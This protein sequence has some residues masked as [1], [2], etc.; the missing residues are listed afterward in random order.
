MKKY[1]LLA[2][3]AGMLSFSVQASDSIDIQEAT[4]EELFAE[5]EETIGIM[6]F[7]LDGYLSGLTGDTRLSL[8]GIEQFAENVGA[9]CAKSPEAKL[10]G[11][12]KI[13]GIE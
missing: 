8:S 13:V 11:V 9:A 5:D 2:V 4:C 10:L 12:A 6:L 1:W 7:W 3:L